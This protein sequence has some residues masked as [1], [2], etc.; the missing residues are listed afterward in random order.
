MNGVDL[1]VISDEQCEAFGL[2]KRK[3]WIKCFLWKMVGKDVERV[4][5]LDCDIDPVAPIKHLSEEPFAAVLD[6]EQTAAKNRANHSRY[7]EI[8]NYFNVGYFSATRSSIGLFEKVIREYNN[9]NNRGCDEQTWISYHANDF[10]CEILDR[11]Y[12]WLVGAGWPIIG[13][14]IH[15]HYAG[16]ERKGD[17]HPEIFKKP[18]RIEREDY[19]ITESYLWTRKGYSC[20]DVWSKERIVGTVLAQLPATSIK[21]AGVD[22]VVRVYQIAAMRLEE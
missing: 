8:R 5:W 12:N 21:L 18:F 10:I 6:I 4:V 19:I 15:F 22:C 7:G 9:P 20:M 11:K 2:M 14:E 16:L 1:Q 3:Y 13:D 17:L